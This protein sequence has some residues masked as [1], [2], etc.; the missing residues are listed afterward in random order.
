MHTQQ[1]S[2]ET[3]MQ[4]LAAAETCFSALGY[5]GTGVAE[6]C[7]QAGVSKGAFYHHFPTK[8]AIF[9]ELLNRWLEGLDT[10]IAQARQDAPNVLTAL[11]TI[12]GMM[13]QVFAAGS[14]RL[15]IFLAFWMKATRDPEAWA[16]TIGHYRHY[17]HLF[18]EMIQAGIADGSVA[19][20]VNPSAAAQVIVSLGAGLILQGLLDPTGA[21]WSRVVEDS[22]HILLEGLRNHA[23]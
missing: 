17:H 6:I 10:Q 2:K 19:P 18:T 11:L 4:L 8:Q 7:R 3:R 15:P 21:D 23:P 9:L 5:D 1:R 22:V 16:V 12:A 14:G 13:R 20:S